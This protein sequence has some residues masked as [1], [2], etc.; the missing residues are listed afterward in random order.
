MTSNPEDTPPAPRVLRGSCSCGRNRYAVLLPTVAETA[1]LVPGQ[2]WIVFHGAAGSYAQLTTTPTPTPYLRIP[3]TNYMSTTHAYFADETPLSI[4]RIY[5]PPAL[6]RAQRG[7]CG[8]CGAGLTYWRGEDVGDQVFREEER[9]SGMM[10]VCL[11]G[12]GR[13][14]WEVLEDVG[15]LEE[16][17]E[18]DETESE[19][20]ADVR[21]FHD[22]HHMDLLRA[23]LR[24]PRPDR[25]A[26]N[27]SAIAHTSY[28]TEL[29]CRPVMSA[30]HFTSWHDAG[31]DDADDHRHRSST[32]IQWEF[33]DCTDGDGD[34][35]GDEEKE[36]KPRHRELLVLT[37][38]ISSHRKRTVEEMD[39]EGEFVTVYE[40]RMQ[41]L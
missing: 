19:D 32:T 38:F 6:P 1:R 7:F 34:G 33:I 31:D 41:E 18:A 12:L 37:P 36:G 9:L 3:L 16:E 26:V 29:G 17:Q 14:G 15:L 23:L 8:Y 35:D 21:Q 25:P 39:P 11:Q 28:Q 24:R 22:H 30:W 2:A 20:A 13:A 27:S 40:V 5:S 10:E 4:R